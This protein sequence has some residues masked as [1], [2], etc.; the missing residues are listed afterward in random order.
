MADTESLQAPGI[1][2]GIVTPLQQVQ[3][4]AFELTLDGIALVLPKSAIAAAWACVQ[5]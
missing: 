3:Q 5:A 2:G 4:Q 1:T